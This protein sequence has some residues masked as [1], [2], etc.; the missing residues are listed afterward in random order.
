MVTLESCVEHRL[1]VMIE[2]LF[3]NLQ[4][5]FQFCC[6]GGHFILLAVNLVG[7]L[8]F[9]VQCLLVITMMISEDRKPSP[10]LDRWNL[11]DIFF[12]SPVLLFWEVIWNHSVFWAAC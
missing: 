2:F 6:R 3:I 5:T 9:L 12:N 10:W 8:Q 4:T 11:K 7:F 1:R